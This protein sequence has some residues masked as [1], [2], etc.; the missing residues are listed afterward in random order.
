MFRL[1]TFDSPSK[2]FPLDVEGDDD[3]AQSTEEQAITLLKNRGDALP[4]TGSAKKITVIGADANITAIGGGTPFVKAV[5][6]TSPLA[7][8]LE[9]AQSAGAE[10]HLGAGQ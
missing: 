3:I 8:I 2:L 5:K 9:R 10:G 4:L 7:G 1:G 6:T